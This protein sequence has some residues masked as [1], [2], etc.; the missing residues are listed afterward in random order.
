MS[1]ACEVSAWWVPRFWCLIKSTPVWSCRWRT[2]HFLKQIQPVSWVFPHP[3]WVLGPP[4]RV[5][6]QTT[7]H[8]VETL[9]FPPLQ[10]RP[11]WCHW[12]GPKVMASIFSGMQRELCSLITFR[13]AKL[14]VGNTMPTCWGSCERQ[15]SPNSLENWRRESCFTRTML[16]H[17]SMWLQF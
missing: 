5:R 11:K 10:R 15:S 8:A 17:T 7:I 1:L 13:K 16:L 12:Q 9:L 3:R 2:W 4:L 6:D 14:S